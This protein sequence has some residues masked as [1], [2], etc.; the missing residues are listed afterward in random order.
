M[1]TERFRHYWLWRFELF[2][3][4]VVFVLASLL[5]AVATIIP[6]V[7]TKSWAPLFEPWWWPLAFIV[8]IAGSI[9]YW[10]KAFQRL[11]FAVTITDDSIHV[12]GQDPARWS[13]ITR[14]EIVVA[15]GD[16]P[17]IRL[18]TAA[19]RIVGV[20]ASTVSLAYIVG[21]VKKHVSNVSDRT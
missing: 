13:E 4:C 12:S 2:G 1:S 16:L 6:M 9:Y 10:V 17:A 11:Q 21:I 3:D 18:Y 14:A 15:G 20:P 5:M 7:R 19:G 8:V